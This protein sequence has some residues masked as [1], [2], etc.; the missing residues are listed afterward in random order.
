MGSKRPECNFF[1]LSAQVQVSCSKSTLSVFTAYTKL[2]C[3]FFMTVLLATQAGLESKTLKP[4]LNALDVENASLILHCTFTKYMLLIH[5]PIPATKFFL[6]KTT[7]SPLFSQLK[8]RRNK[9]MSLKLNSAPSL[10]H[11]WLGLEYPTFHPVKCLQQIWCKNVFGDKVISSFDNN[12][13]LN[14]IFIEKRIIVQQLWWCRWINICSL[15]RFDIDSRAN[16]LSW[17]TTT[18]NLSVWS[19]WTKSMALIHIILMYSPFLQL[20]LERSLQFERIRYY[21]QSFW[22]LLVSSVGQEKRFI[23]SF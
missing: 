19:L 21:F 20:F 8:D 7:R 17:I 3:A 9:N 12:F 13:G 5:V 4:S 14:Y 6:L 15:I 10:V 18:I 11:R 16:W 1:F 23:W 22:R 2:L